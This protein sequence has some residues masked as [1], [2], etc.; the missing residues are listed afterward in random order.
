MYADKEFWPG[1]IKDISAGGLGL[2]VKHRFEPGTLLRVDVSRSI[3]DAPPT[4]WVCVV[5]LVPQAGGEWLLGCTQVRPLEH[6]ELNAFLH[7]PEKVCTV[8]HE[9]EATSP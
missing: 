6:E 2:L 3:P 4:L 5:R 1:R 8:V 9:L 7:D